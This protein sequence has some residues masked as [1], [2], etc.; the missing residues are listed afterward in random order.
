MD[1]D[2]FFTMLLFLFFII[3]FIIYKIIIKKIGREKFYQLLYVVS[4]FILIIYFILNPSIIISLF[5]EDIFTI[6]FVSIIIIFGIIAWIYSLKMQIDEI[7][8]YR[9]LKRE[10]NQESKKV[11]IIKENKKIYCTNC[12]KEIDIKWIHCKYCGSKQE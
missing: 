8:E 12:G 6:I 3:L 10:K 1:K 2:D 4:V 9:N 5:S 7:K 11:N